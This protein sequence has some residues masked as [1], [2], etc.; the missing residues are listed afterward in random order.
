[1]R[2]PSWHLL[3]VVTSVAQRLGTGFKYLQRSVP[4]HQLFWIAAV[5]ETDGGGTHGCQKGLGETA[6]I[7]KGKCHITRVDAK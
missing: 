6:L 3:A 2:L 5:S 7:R 4:V 1:M